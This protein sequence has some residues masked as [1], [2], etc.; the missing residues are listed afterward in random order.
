MDV[1]YF[2]FET[3]EN[4]LTNEA[5]VWAGG[6][7]RACGDQPVF[8]RNIK[9]FI[10]LLE[11]GRLSMRPK[12]Y[13]HD[14]K[15]DGYF[16]VDYLE[17]NGFSKAIKKNIV[18]LEDGTEETKWVWLDK[19]HMIPNTY[20]CFIDRN[21]NWYNIVIK[22]KFV[23]VIIKDS[24][25]VLPFSLKDINKSFELDYDYIDLDC[26]NRSYM[27]PLSVLD[28]TAIS[29]KLFIIENAMKK[30][31]T[32]GYIQD[33]IGNCALEFFKDMIGRFDYN[34]LFP[35]IFKDKINSDLYGSDSV[36]EYILK[37]YL[38]SFVYVNPEKQNKVVK[39]GI[40]LD[41]NSLYPFTVHKSFGVKYPVGHGTI[42]SGRASK[43]EG[44][45]Y[46]QRLKC[47]FKLRDGFLPFIK[48]K[49][50][51][52]YNPRECLSSSDIV[53][54][55]GTRIRNVVELTLTQTE[56]KMFYK[57]YHVYN[58]EYLDYCEFKVANGIFDK[59]ID[60]F[61]S[62]KSNAKNN[63]QR[64]I[65]KLL[66]NS[67]LGKFGATY[68]STFKIP[69]LS[70]KDN[71]IKMRHQFETDATPGYIPIGS[72]VL[73]EARCYI[74]NIC[75][76]NY[77]PGNKGFC[78]SDSDS[79]HVD[80]DLD[81]VVG[82]PCIDNKKLG[83]FKVEKEWDKAWFNRTKR[84]VERVTAMNGQPVRE[85][86]DIVCAGLTDRSK[87]LYRKSL[88]DNLSD[89]ELNE[90]NENITSSEEKFIKIKRS[91][92]SFSCDI[93]IPG[94]KLR[95]IIPGGAVDIDGSFGFKN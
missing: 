83:A 79:L 90:L 16:I 95:K 78:Y 85:F 48:M 93:D 67:L 41:C 94:I 13:S 62:E 42:K 36:G 80:F 63:V 12:I 46:F 7:L 27:F 64:V 23:T 77:H 82:V 28:K 1:F 26:N 21:G 38:G 18:K 53:L 76:Q 71:I 39:N 32:D 55:S 10:N 31:R 73:S 75:N 2:R 43:E 49:N 5:E 19:K 25:K 17:R 69:F 29:N 8:F 35:N 57:H 40:T 11:C 3:T 59:Y 50:T 20:T 45:Y 92:K 60:K 87:L 86:H 88:G 33:T 4:K 6:I 58:V 22:F 74:V 65:S 89:S 72:F 56:L 47:E 91:L 37:S 81:H 9:D 44:K 34:L 30:F 54:E 14:L 52:M 84:Y 70:E 24:S 61:V 68:Y 51:Y 15:F 66:L